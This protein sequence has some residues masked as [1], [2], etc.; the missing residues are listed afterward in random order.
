MGGGENMHKK[1]LEAMNRILEPI[2]KQLE[3]YDQMMNIPIA[4]DISKASVLSHEEVSKIIEMQS[5]L[6][7]NSFSPFEA[8]KAKRQQIEKNYANIDDYFHPE[9]T[10]SEEL[11]RNVYSL[12]DE[13]SIPVHEKIITKEKL[14]KKQ[15][16]TYEELISV[17][18]IISSFLIFG[19]DKIDS[20]Y[21]SLQDTKPHQDIVDFLNGIHG[22]TFTK[23]ED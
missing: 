5:M 3:I 13:F 2:Q 12:I 4:N 23:I 7:E 19:I 20:Y 21:S 18:G 8:T 22:K 11:S 6:Y 1:Y 16:L 15:R 17:I 14:E 10:I 9:F